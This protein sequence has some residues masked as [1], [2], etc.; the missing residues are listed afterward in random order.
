[1]SDLASLSDADLRKRIAELR[2][3][4]ERSSDRLVSARK[5]EAEARERLEGAQYELQ[6]RRKP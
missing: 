3:Q 1:M 2:I 5:V 6:R 4:W